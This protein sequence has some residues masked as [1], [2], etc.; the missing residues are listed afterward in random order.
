MPDETV[1]FL[2]KAKKLISKN[3]RSVAGRA[4]F[5]QGLAQIG[6]LNIDEIWRHIMDLT[7]FQ[8]IPDYKPAY[9]GGQE[10]FIFKK[11]INGHEVY[12]KIKIETHKYEESLVCISFHKM[13]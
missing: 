11:N 7:K 3:K 9:D 1:T 8:R 5:V 12:I 2:S 10:A 13:N 4:D 6:I